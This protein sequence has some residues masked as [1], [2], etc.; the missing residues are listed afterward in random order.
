MFDEKIYRRFNHT[1]AACFVIYFLFPQKIMG[2][3]RIYLVILLWIIILGIEYL[4][5]NKN[6]NLFGMRDYESDRIAGF[7]WFASG[8][9]IILG[10][11]E[12]GAF[13]QS[14]AIATIIMAAYTDPVIGEANL[15]LGDRWGLGIGFVCSFVIYQL[16]VGVIFYSVLGGLIAVLVER[17]KLKWFDDD[18][19]M[20]IFPISILSILWLSGIGPD[21]PETIIGSGL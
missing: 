5:L 8:T 3:E 19:A 21:L 10:F 12:M 1:V 17:P 2:L 6:L 18:L 20:Q 7:V 15:K 4:R 16:I 9:F 14:L 13:P 11:Y